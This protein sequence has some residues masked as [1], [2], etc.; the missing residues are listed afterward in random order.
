MSIVVGSRDGVSV[1]RLE[2]G[3]RYDDGGEV[4]WLDGSLVAASFPGND[5]GLRD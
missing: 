2:V 1:S 3:G 5:D 4:G